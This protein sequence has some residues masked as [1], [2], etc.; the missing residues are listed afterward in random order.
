MEE[1]RVQEGIFNPYDEPYLWRV[2]LY[3]ISKYAPEFYEE[4]IFK[5]RAAATTRGK[6]V[7]EHRVIH[8]SIQSLENQIISDLG[9]I[10][11][12]PMRSSHHIKPWN[13]R[14]P[15]PNIGEAYQ[16]QLDQL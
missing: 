9:S 8:Q 15:R 3:L 7:K 16:D 11:M 5:I 10:P 13:K 14:T 6:I 2:E 1:Q 12:T 4:T